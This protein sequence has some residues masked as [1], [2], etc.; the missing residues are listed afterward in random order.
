MS[1]LTHLILSLHGWVALAIVFL[2]PALEASAFIGFLFPGEIAVLLGGVLAFEGRIPLPAAI[3]AAVLG[4]VLGDTAGYFIGKRW[5][6]AI[7]NGTV[8]RLVKKEH[9]DRAEDY[10]KRRGGVAIFFGRFTAALRVMVPGL[11]GM[12]NLPY[13][14][15]FAYNFA[16]G[17][18]WGAGFV[19]LGFVAGASW[20]QVAD[21]ASRVGLALLG[22]VVVALVASRLVRKA[23]VRAALQN[24]GMAPRESKPIVWAN[25]HFPNQLGWLGR[26]LDPS[27]P[28]G[29][30]LSF[31]L[32]VVAFAT[33]LFAG[34][35]QDVFAH[36]E[37]VR[38]DP[39]VERYV[40]AHR[41]AWLTEIM[42]VVTWLASN[43]ILI[44]LVV[45]IASWFIIKRKDWVTAA[46]LGAVLG[47]AV[48]LNDIF[49]VWVG[50]A[51]PPVQFMIGSFSGRAF[52]SGHATTAIAVYAAIAFLVSRGRS[53]SLRV[54][55][56]S[57]A[58]FI[59]LVVGISPIYLGAHW[60]TDVVGG[61]A[62][63][64]LWVGTLIAL[65]IAVPLLGKRVQGMEAKVGSGWPS[66]SG[67]DELMPL[68][69]G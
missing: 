32:S 31:A 18:L 64:T 40:L 21:I 22:L 63:G 13:S 57:A 24:E 43:A 16:G 46:W 39:G 52:P 41:T 25:R 50:R 60:F 1:S 15:F 68:T 28:T 29:F 58:A 12:S 33:W 54:A 36:E 47:G 14:T 65:L 69:D 62:L 6:R 37:S 17:V 34:V 11:A 35:T 38:L 4:A 23:R 5:G 10:L 66:G 45:L 3:A 49:K 48:L 61:F 67:R 51:R 56:W 30:A 26:R 7:L 2:G 53:P 9:L 19:I 20:H 27:A 42:K 59:V 55:I 8:G 44:P